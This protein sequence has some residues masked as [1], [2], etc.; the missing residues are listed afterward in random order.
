MKQTD[1]QMKLRF[2][3]ELKGKIESAAKANNRSMNAEIVARLMESFIDP[4]G[5]NINERR[6]LEL[7]N[8]YA[9]WCR[10]T[11]ADPYTSFGSYAQAYV[12]PEHQDS[13]DHVSFFNTVD[14]HYLSEL[15][16][17]WILERP[18]RFPLLADRVDSTVRQPISPRSFD[19]DPVFLAEIEKRAAE[20][21]CSKTQALIRM[22]IEEV[23]V[24]K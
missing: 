11:G 15:F 24:K 3:V 18:D 2:P 22:T 16:S 19:P 21:G 4:P 6:K 9:K 12:A 1:P 8:S 17:V 5:A 13:I 23:S 20:W 7:V 14:P 10:D